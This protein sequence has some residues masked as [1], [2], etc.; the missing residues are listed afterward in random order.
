[1]WVFT[2]Y[3]YLSAVN[4]RQGDGNRSNPADPDKILIRARNRSHLENLVARFSDL[5]SFQIDEDKEGKRDYRYMMIVPKKVWC[6]VLMELGDEMD[7]PKFKSSIVE[8]DGQEEYH[9][10]LLDVWV[11]TLQDQSKEERELKRQTGAVFGFR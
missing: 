3:G 11:R 1:M 2:K 5:E 4:A 9:N 6:Q 10:T 8:F 7:Y